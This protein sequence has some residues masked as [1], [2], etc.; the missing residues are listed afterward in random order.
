MGAAEGAAERCGRSRPLRLGRDR[1][2]LGPPGQ[3][4][5]PEDHQ[6]RATSKHDESADE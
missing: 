3:T 1:N 4:T 6:H 2:R 5:A